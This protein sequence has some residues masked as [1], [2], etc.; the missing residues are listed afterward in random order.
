M[1]VY[2][3]DGNAPVLEEWQ[4]GE[5][6]S[7]EMIFRGKVAGGDYHANMDGDMFMKW[8]NEHYS[9]MKISFFKIQFIGTIESMT[10]SIFF[11]ETKVL[12]QLTHDVNAIDA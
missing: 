6:G 5:T 3:D 12:E 10:C 4:T 1:L 2:D 9:K 7:C 8:I 11:I